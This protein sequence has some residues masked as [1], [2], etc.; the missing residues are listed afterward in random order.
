[1]ELK[2]TYDPTAKAVY[3]H[4]TTIKAGDV[5]R[6]VEAIPQSVMLDFDHENRLIGIEVL[7]ADYL[8]PRE[9]WKGAQKPTLRM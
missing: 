5:A 3:I 7:N 8:L 9:V 4:L 6:T 1:M 2:V